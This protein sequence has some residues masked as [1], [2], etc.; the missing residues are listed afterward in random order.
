MTNFQYSWA[1]IADQIA[2]STSD[3]LGLLI[4]TLTNGDDY[5]ECTRPL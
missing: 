3:W 1:G 5:R 4:Y 2:V